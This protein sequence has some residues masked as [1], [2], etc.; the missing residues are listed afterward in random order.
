MTPHEFFYSNNE[1]KTLIKRYAGQYWEDFYQDFYFIISNQCQIKLKDIHERGELKYYFIRIIFNQLRSN[2]SKS[3]INQFKN[4]VPLESVLEI[5]DTSIDFEEELKIN[6]LNLEI[7]RVINQPR[8]IKEWHE[9][10]MLLLLIN[11]GSLRLVS[12]KTGIAKSTVS[13]IINR[14]KDRIKSDINNK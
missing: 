12:K 2:S 11:E 5:Q 1:F 13:D 10:T 4:E 3:F 6:S 7:E 8:N 14:A 9:N